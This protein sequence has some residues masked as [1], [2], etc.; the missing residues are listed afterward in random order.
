[1]ASSSIYKF[2]NNHPSVKMLA[3]AFLMLIGVTLLAEGFGEKIPK[4]YIYAA[5]AFSVFVETLNIGVRR[6]TK[7]PVDLHTH[8]TPDPDS[9]YADT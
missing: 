9:E 7:E 1:V 6:K 2:V 8:M 5:M 4:G 3:L